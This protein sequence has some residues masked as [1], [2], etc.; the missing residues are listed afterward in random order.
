MS[1]K[2][3]RRVRRIDHVAAKVGVVAANVIPV[4][5]TAVSV[6]GA[7]AIAA[8]QVEANKRH[9]KDAQQRAARTKQIATAAFNASYEIVKRPVAPNPTAPA[10]GGTV[11]NA[12]PPVM[13]AAPGGARLRQQS[14]PKGLAIAAIAILALAIAAKR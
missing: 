5:G 7:A 10:D 3:R 8:N 12:A 4:V 2:W 9:A 6:A 14:L 11:G 1:K 13:T